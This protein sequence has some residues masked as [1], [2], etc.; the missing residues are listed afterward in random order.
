MDDETTATRG[1]ENKSHDDQRELLM[2]VEDASNTHVDSAQDDD[3]EDFERD[4]RTTLCKKDGN[5][6]ITSRQKEDDCEGEEK[7]RCHCQT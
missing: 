5:I 7:R 1:M 3:Q 4:M 2:R 6:D